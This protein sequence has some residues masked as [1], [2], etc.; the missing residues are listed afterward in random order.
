[1]TGL[2]AIGQSKWARVAMAAFLLAGCAIAPI[3]P[4]E[5]AWAPDEDWWAEA[6]RSGGRFVGKDG[7]ILR[8]KAEH[9]RNL[10]EVAGR[11]REQSAIA[12]QIAFVDAAELNAYAI[13]AGGVRQIAISLPLLDAIGDD[14][15]ALATTIGHEA[16]HMHYGHEAARKVRGQLT[17]GDPAAI[18]GILTVNTSFSRYEEREADL[19]GM[20]WAVAAGFSPCGSARTMRVIGAHDA[21]PGENAFLSMHPGH[22]E[23]IERANDLS[24]RLGGRAC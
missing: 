7:S 19:K 8:V 16:A 2:R 14:R 13:Q 20:E 4:S 18:A 24:R 3:A 5:T 10:R 17:M 15:D 12:A 23:R 11:I 1:M 21:A 22:G 9:A 6:G